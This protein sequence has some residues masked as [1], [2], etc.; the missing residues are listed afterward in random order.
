MSNLAKYH[1]RCQYC[2]RMYWSARPEA[3]YDT[4]RCQK[5]GRRAE[6]ELAQLA[7]A[8]AQSRKGSRKG[9]QNQQGLTKAGKP[10]TKLARSTKIP[11]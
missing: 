6:V 5:A 2:G 11:K 9:I 3:K 1:K 8:A 10:R 7:A 4:G